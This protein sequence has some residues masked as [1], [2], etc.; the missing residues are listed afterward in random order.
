MSLTSIIIP[1]YNGLH[2]LK[3][4]IE[5]IRTHTVD[6]PYEIIVVDNA[7]NDG[8]DTFCEAERLINVRLPEN[9]GFPAACNIG[10]RLASG[11]QF[12][13]LNNDVTVTPG[14]LSNMLAALWSD[15]TVG[16]VGPVTNYVS[17]IQQIHGLGG[18]LSSCLRFAE[19][20]NASNPSRWQEVKRLVGF[21]VLLRRELMERIGLLDER[22]SPGHYED[23]DYCLRAHLHGYKLLMCSDCFVYHQGNASFSRVDTSR[24]KELIE[25][26]YRLF[27]EKWSIDPRMFIE[28]GNIGIS[29]TEHAVEGGRKI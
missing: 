13:I 14:W 28:S 16:L 20:N 1:T 19:Q 9:R 11:D 4:C 25:R 21:C 3:P 8:T 10:L 12:V 15:S 5:A 27:I 23:D 22:F 2:L 17:G 29:C 6:V 26:N 7:S 18:D 24:I